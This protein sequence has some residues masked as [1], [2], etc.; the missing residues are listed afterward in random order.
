MDPDVTVRKLRKDAY[1]A[2]L[3]VRVARD[4]IEMSTHFYPALTVGARDIEDGVR[5]LETALRRVG[6]AAG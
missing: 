4:G 3:L 5:A 2:G 1:D 6:E